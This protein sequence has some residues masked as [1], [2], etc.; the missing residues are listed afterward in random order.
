MNYWLL[1]SEPHKYSFF[2]L[3]RDKKTIWDGVRNFQARNNLRAMKLNDHALYYHSNEGKE[4]VGVAKIIKEAYPDPT[5][6][7][8][9]WSV[10]EIAPIEKL[11]TTVTLEQ[12]KATPKLKSMA[13]LKQSRLSVSPVTKEEFNLIVEM[14]R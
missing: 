11:E 5:A 7:E 14:G 2:D 3:V 1:K 9:N 10:V 13:L 8:G 12:I 4:I 6:K